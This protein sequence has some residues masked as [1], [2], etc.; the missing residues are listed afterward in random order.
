MVTTHFEDYNATN[1]DSA[2]SLKGLVDLVGDKIAVAKEAVRI[3]DDRDKVK[4]EASMKKADAIQSIADGFKKRVEAKLR[5]YE[6]KEVLIDTLVMNLI[7]V[8]FYEEKKAAIRMK[9]LG[10]SSLHE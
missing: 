9:R 3:R 8:V 10:Q 4:S 1:N 7:S 2:Q 5:K 6:I